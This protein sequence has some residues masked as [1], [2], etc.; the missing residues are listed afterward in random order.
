MQIQTVRTFNVQN[1]PLNIRSYG[2]SNY[3]RIQTVRTFNVHNFPLNL[4]SS[5]YSISLSIHIFRTFNV[6][7]FPLNLNSTGYLISLQILT[8]RTYKMD[9]ISH[10]IFLILDIQFLRKARHSILIK[11][12][13]FPDELTKFWIFNFSANPDSLNIYNVHNFSPNLRNFGY[14]ISLQN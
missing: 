10:W 1:F 3:L 13:Q 14:S 2:F 9:T 8:F 6:N 4:S 12:T 11:C 7:N 5:G